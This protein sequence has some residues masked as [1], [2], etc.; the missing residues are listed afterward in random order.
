LS[1]AQVRVAVQ[2]HFLSHYREPIFS[3]MSSQVGP[4]PHYTF[5]SGTTSPEGVAIIDEE[6][7]G[8]NVGGKKRIRWRSVKNWW[9]G[10]T[11]LFQPG[12][13]SLG[14]SRDY[15]CIIYLGSMYHLS[16]WLSAI[17][18]KISGKRVLMWTHGYL[19]EERG[20]RGYLRAL[21]YRLADGLL[22]YGDRGRELL[23]RR[24]FDASRLYVV[25]NSLDYQAQRAIRAEWGW[26]RLHELRGEL[27][28]DPN[29]SILIFTGRLTKRKGLDLIFCAQ[30][31]LRSQGVSVNAII[32]GDGPDK[33]RL[34]DFMQRLNL[35]RNVWFVGECY[36]EKVLGPLLMASD[37]CVSPGEVGLTCIHAMAYG[38]PVATHDDADTQGPECEAIVPGETGVLFKKGDCRALSRGISK[39]LKG[40]APRETVARRC[41]N[42]V[43]ISYS[44]ENQL[45]ILNGAVA[46]LEAG[47]LR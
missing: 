38:T 6:K 5:F 25:F 34:I 17:L 29:A 47:E 1:K 20:P 44:P 40:R 2:Q 41:I 26:E 12:V 37:L 16:T 31:A 46:G 7:L 39:F 23:L 21:F 24:G 45:R 19:K 22:L 33:A 11:F 8:L 13:V 27:F 42:A 43:E 4:L 30:D 35:S 10:K 15:D 18:A 32:V 14:M 9:L 28:A 36:D 3:L